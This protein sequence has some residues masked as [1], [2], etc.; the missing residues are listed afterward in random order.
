MSGIFFRSLR[1]YYDFAHP[2]QGD[3]SN[4][5]LLSRQ[6]KVPVMLPVMLPIVYCS[7]G[8]KSIGNIAGFSYLIQVYVSTA[9]VARIPQEY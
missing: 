3:S 4:E 7:F 1:V 2:L 9:L 8:S 5:R 6:I